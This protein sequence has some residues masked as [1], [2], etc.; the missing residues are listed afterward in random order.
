[1]RRT[2][3]RRTTPLKPASKRRTAVRDTGPSPETVA[4]VLTRDGFA[5]VGCGIRISGERGRDWSLQHRR[6]RGMGG[7]RRDDTNSPANLL[8]VCGSGTT[9]CHGQMESHRA[10]ALENGWLITQDQD[11]AAV[12]VLVGHG[13][14]WVLLTHDGLY[15]DC[16]DPGH[17]AVGSTDATHL[18]AREGYN[19]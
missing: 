12:P 1:M 18:Q 6:P 15:H 8:T 16:G 3:L 13:S 17:S 19:P 9:G 5:C 7:T 2:P 14:R 10:E 11:P 4:Q